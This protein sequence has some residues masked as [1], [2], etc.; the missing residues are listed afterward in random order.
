MGNWLRFYN[1]ENN[2]V[3]RLKWN[4]MNLMRWAFVRCKNLHGEVVMS[5]C[6]Y[7]GFVC[8]NNCH[9]DFACS[10]LII[11]HR[12]LDDVGRY[13]HFHFQFGNNFFILN[14]SFNQQFYCFFFI[15]F[16]C[17]ILLSE[18]RWE[19]THFNFSWNLFLWFYSTKLGIN[20]KVSQR[21]VNKPTNIV[22]IWIH[23]WSFGATS[24]ESN[25]K[26]RANDISVGYCHAYCY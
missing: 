10:N 20:W 8:T 18:N 25:K 12:Q 24:G 6:W 21:N 23:S 5:L 22:Y 26:L 13:V 1:Y 4:N 14:E 17:F 15:I 7:A 16:Q 2:F 11:I 3:P 19:G 9:I